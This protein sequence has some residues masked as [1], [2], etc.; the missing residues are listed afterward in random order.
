MRTIFISLIC[1]SQ[2]AIFSQQNFKGVLLDSADKS[3]VEFANIGIVGKS[4]GTVT[5]EKGEFTITVPDSLL[6]ENIR[7]SIIGYKAQ[8]FTASAL[9]RRP[10]I[11]I[12]RNSTAL[13]EVVVQVKKTKI[14]IL[15]NET[16]TKTVAAGFKKNSLGSEIAVRLDIK[17]VNTQ[18]RKFFVNIND[19]DIGLPVFR[20]N[21]YSVS[22]DG[23]PKDNLLTKNVL[24]TPKDSIG[25]ISY[26]LMPLDIVVNDDVFISI[27]WVKDLGD[28]S[29][30]RFSTK[31]FGSATYFRQASQGKWEKIAPIGVGLYAEVG[32]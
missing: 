10:T 16:K 22:A 4:L 2:F 30:L 18:L 26:D 14:K 6:N 27:E 1:L 28:V 3:P 24:I 29:G 25:L 5:N 23:L 20:F 19:N 9:A 11:Y 31:L 15:G 21:V 17:H 7:I 12:S 8:L 32:Y 13:S